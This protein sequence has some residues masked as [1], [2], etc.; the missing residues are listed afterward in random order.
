MPR[1]RFSLNN[2]SFLHFPVHPPKT[3]LE[4]Q[5]RFHLG[6]PMRAKLYQSP[7]ARVHSPLLWWPRCPADL[8]SSLQPSAVL[9]CTR[10]HLLPARDPSPSEMLRVP[11][12]RGSPTLQPLVQC[13]LTIPSSPNRNPHK[14]S[15]PDP[16]K[17]SSQKPASSTKNFKAPF[18]D[19]PFLLISS[20]VHAL[21]GENKASAI[22][23]RSS[24]VP[25]VNRDFVPLAG[26]DK[27]PGGLGAQQAQ[28][29]SGFAMWFALQQ[30]CWHRCCNNHKK[31]PSNISISSP[32]P[33]AL[34]RRQERQID[35]P[36]TLA[37][38]PCNP[39]LIK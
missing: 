26:S 16:L 13:S 8:N 12:W 24:W 32:Q 19:C 3:Y 23:W 27:A 5:P 34:L 1:C 2:F 7:L 35:K 33:F 18:P 36:L 11:M 17:H 38:R 22:C 37:Q 14:A 21:H 30:S 20:T 39:N 15:L 28:R 29:W 10:F 25:P 6:Q 31:I 9:N 4:Q